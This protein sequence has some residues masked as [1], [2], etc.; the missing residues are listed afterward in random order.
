MK[1]I[2]YKGETHTFTEWCRILRSQPVQQILAEVDDV[3]DFVQT[4]DF[5]ESGALSN[6][7]LYN[8]YK[9]RSENP[10]SRQNFVKRVAIAFK[11]Y[12][13][14]VVRYHTTYERGWQVRQ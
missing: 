2:T 14:D 10:V 9:A 5:G 12:R 13:P 7:D 6:A 4:L 3:A 11:K 8:L 1:L